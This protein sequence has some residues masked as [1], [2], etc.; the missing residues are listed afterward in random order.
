MNIVTILQGPAYGKKRA[1]N[2]LRL[3]SNLAK[4]DDQQDLCFGDAVGYAVAVRSGLAAVVAIH[5][6][7]EIVEQR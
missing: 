2:R 4:R 6:V 7:A 5:E 3:A 1:R